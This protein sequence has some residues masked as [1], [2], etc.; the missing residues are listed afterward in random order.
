[1]HSN[2]MRCFLAVLLDFGGDFSYMTRY[3]EKQ[4]SDLLTDEQTDA[5]H[6]QAQQTIR[7]LKGL[8]SDVRLNPTNPKGVTDQ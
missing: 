1:M 3:G 5:D 7:Y 8:V 4:R 2:P 6:S